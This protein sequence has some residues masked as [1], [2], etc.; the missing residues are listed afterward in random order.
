MSTP[1][2]VVTVVFSVLGF[3]LIVIFASEL[4][5][6]NKLINILLKD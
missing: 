4:E 2:I 6:L 5:L 3:V 1:E